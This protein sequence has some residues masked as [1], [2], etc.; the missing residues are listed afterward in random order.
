M[1]ERRYVVGRKRLEKYRSVRRHVRFPGLFRRAHI[2]RQRLGSERRFWLSQ[3]SVTIEVSSAGNRIYWYIPCK[4]RE[5][6]SGMNLMRTLRRRYI[7][8]PYSGDFSSYLSSSLRASCT[9]P[10]P[11]ASN[12]TESRLVYLSK[13]QPPTSTMAA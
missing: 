9:P 2:V 12:S 1:P 3:L 5:V 7:I 6:P 11:F 8:K 10:F 13:N 4:S